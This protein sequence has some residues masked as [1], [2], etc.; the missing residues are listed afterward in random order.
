MGLIE[1]HRLG[2][3]HAHYEA[4]QDAPHYHFVCLQCGRV[5]EFE[6]PLVKQ[7][8]QT[9]SQEH[10]LCVDDTHVRLSGYCPRCTELAKGHCNED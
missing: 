2:Q 3:E 1:E 5:I 7:A 6:S 4:A 8:I 10:G 9:F